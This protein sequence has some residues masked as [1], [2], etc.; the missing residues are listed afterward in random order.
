[1]Y[2]VYDRVGVM[3][4]PASRVDTVVGRQARFTDL[5]M[6]LAFAQRMN[7]NAPQYGPMRVMRVGDGTATQEVARY[8]NGKRVM[9]DVVR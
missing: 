6:A 1:M 8:V 4:N 9:Y 2:V 5:D 7:A 3:S